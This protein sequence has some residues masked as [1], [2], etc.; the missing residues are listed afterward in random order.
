MIGRFYVQLVLHLL[1]IPNLC[2]DILFQIEDLILLVAPDHIDRRI[3]PVRFFFCISSVP[4]ALPDKPFVPDTMSNE[5]S[6][7]CLRVWWT[8][9]RQTPCL[10]ANCLS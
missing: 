1:K 8:M 9:S 2:I 4:S 10:S 3:Q 7:G 6:A 5:S